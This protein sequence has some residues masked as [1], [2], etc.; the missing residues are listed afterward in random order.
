MISLGIVALL[1]IVTTSVL[2]FAGVRVIGWLQARDR[3]L[4]AAIVV[5]AYVLVFKL[6]S[7]WWLVSDLAVLST[8]LVVGSVIGSALRSPAAVVS[9]CVVAGIVD[10]FSFSGGLTRTIVESFQ[11]GDSR[12]LI[13]LSIAVPVGGS[14]R[15]IVGIGDLIVLAGLFAG[16]GHL[17]YG[18]WLP[19]AVPVVGLLLALGVGLV[20]G[21]A[22]ALPFIAVA[23]IVYVLFQQKHRNVSHAQH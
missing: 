11:L 14:V 13:H 22:P 23:T 7:G 17:R 19:F 2:I 5:V 3:V 10:V 8:A 6:E 18:G 21:G 20:A 1:A 15:P 12:V 4:V 16:F 9:F